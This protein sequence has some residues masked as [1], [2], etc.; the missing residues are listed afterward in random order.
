[1]SFSLTP[2]QVVF[3]DAGDTLV[4]RSA[5]AAPTSRFKWVTGAKAALSQLGAAGVR[6]GLLSNAPAMTR[7]Q[8][9]ARLPADFRF[10]VFEPALVIISSEVGLEKPDP[11][12]FALAVQRAGVPAAECLF[13]TEELL[14]VLA[15]QQAGMRSAW[16]PTGRIRQFVEELVVTGL[17]M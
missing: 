4:Y 6:L 7:Q 8:L 16:V 15:A 1:M 10:D 11:A 3:F 12:I 9:Q 13:C 5:T 17:L 2:V 14:H